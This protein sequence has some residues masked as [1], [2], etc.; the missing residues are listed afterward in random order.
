MGKVNLAV[1][2]KYWIAT[3]RK[4]LL[5]MTASAQAYISFLWLSLRGIL[6]VAMED[7]AIQENLGMRKI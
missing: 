7:E 4:A 1:D 6:S 2:R 5:A 3:S